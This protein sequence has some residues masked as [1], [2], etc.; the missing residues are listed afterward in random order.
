MIPLSTTPPAGLPAGAS[1][2]SPGDEIVLSHRT[3]DGPPLTGTFTGWSGIRYTISFPDGTTRRVE[4]ATWAMAVSPKAA[5]ETRKDENSFARNADFGYTDPVQTSVAADQLVSESERGSSSTTL[6]PFHDQETYMSN[7]KWVWDTGSP[8]LPDGGLDFIRSLFGAGYTKEEKAQLRRFRLELDLLRIKDEKAELLHKKRLR[9]L[10]LELAED[11]HKTKRQE[12]AEKTDKAKEAS[13]EKSKEDK[14]KQDKAKA[15]PD[16]RVAAEEAYRASPSPKTLAALYSARAAYGLGE[17]ATADLENRPDLIASVSTAAYAAA[18]LRIQAGDKPEEVKA[19]LVEITTQLA[20]YGEVSQQSA[21]ERRMIEHLIDLELKAASPKATKAAVAEA[22]ATVAADH[23]DIAAATA[24]EMAARDAH[25]PATTAAAATISAAETG[26]DYGG[27]AS[28]ESVRANP[29]GSVWSKISDHH[30][31]LTISDQVSYEVV[32]SDGQWAVARLDQIGGYIHTSFPADMPTRRE[33]AFE[34]AT[35]H[36]VSRLSLDTPPGSQP[37]DIIVARHMALATLADRPATAEQIDALTVAPLRYSDQNLAEVV[38]VHSP[39]AQ[40]AL[41][42]ALEEHH[43]QL[44]FTPEEYAARTETHNQIAAERQALVAELETVGHQAQVAYAADPDIAEAIARKRGM[45]DQIDAAFAGNR[46]PEEATAALLE[47]G[48]PKV[49]ITERLTVLAS[50]EATERPDSFETQRT[51]ALGDLPKVAD[52]VAEYRASLAEWC[53]LHNEKSR[54]PEAKAAEPLALARYEDAA[55]RLTEHLPPEE[56]QTNPEW[57]FVET[58]A[59]RA[60]DRLRP[61]AHLGRFL[62]EQRRDEPTMQ[63]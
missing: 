51:L 39:A 40:A 38:G 59:K 22:A 49:T 42:K 58:E 14:A 15:R 30:Y 9:E 3:K 20:S 63:L 35:A 43:L 4:A 32:K 31:T 53:A 11:E 50:R 41:V 26:S 2:F 44:R 45:I 34:I 27:A 8:I 47:A 29:F 16:G 1:L 10:Q 54:S 56:L 37:V 7:S 25:G 61:A 57:R 13:K 62:Q 24:A 60:I 55:L 5:P 46:D 21:A 18:R 19:T 17:L 36:A 52:P 48:I 23:P 28:L 6:P 33:Q 12:A